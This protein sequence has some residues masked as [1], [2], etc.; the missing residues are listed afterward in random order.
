MAIRKT[1]YVLAFCARIGILCARYLYSVIDSTPSP[2]EYGSRIES[3][4]ST[5]DSGSRIDTHMG[6]IPC[7]M[8]SFDI[9]VSKYWMASNMMEHVMY[10]IMSDLFFPYYLLYRLS[11]PQFISCDF[12][13]FVQNMVKSSCIRMR[14][15]LNN[16][17]K[18]A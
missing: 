6:K 3:T 16:M 1:T 5:W 13:K 2:W 14:Y 9:K 15:W 4:P 17:S 7:K 18:S 10:V 12:M 11:T 8:P